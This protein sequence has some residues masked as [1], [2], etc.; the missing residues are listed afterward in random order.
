MIKRE[1]ERERERE[2]DQMSCSGNKGKPDS[3]TR[4]GVE[5]VGFRDT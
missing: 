3:I 1:R 5:V 4:D 2:R